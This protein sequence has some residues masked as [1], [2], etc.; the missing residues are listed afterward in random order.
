MSELTQ[1]LRMAVQARHPLLYLHSAEENRVLMALEELSVEFFAGAPLHV[2]TCVDGLAPS[3]DADTRDPVNAVQAALASKEDG[4][5]V[6]HDLSAFLDDPGVVRALRQAYFR[7]QHNPRKVLAIVSPV[8]TIPPELE[9][10]TYL[11][12]VPLPEST[13]LLAEAKRIQDQYAGNAIPAEAEPAVSLALRG[14]TL[15]EV[16]H[17]MHRVF[18]QG[19]A[20]K[21]AILDQIFQEKKRLIRKASF[22]EFVPQR[23]DIARIGGL[24]NLKEWALN[25]R[26]MFTSDA[27]AAGLPIPRGVLIMG[28]SGCGKSM[29]AKALASLWDLPLFRLDMNLIF[30][31]MHGSPHAA[32]HKAMRAIEAVAPAVL[33]IDE[34]ESALG[35]TVG[36]TT[37]DQALT[38][39]SFLTWMQERPPLVFVAATANRIESMP[40]EVIRKGRFDHVFFCDLP[41]TVERLEILRIHLAINGARPDEVDPER[42]L[43]STKGWSGAEIEQ[44]IVS[45]RIDALKAGRRFNT[46]DVRRHTIS[47]VPLSETMEEQVRAIRSWAFSRATR[48]S[49]KHGET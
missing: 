1:D 2:W 44:A 3:H 16:G 34:I 46:E 24:E 6:F 19:R 40:A 35:M 11:I 42:L 15:N 21:E 25:R 43:N 7:L 9:N 28:V 48:A 36:D 23:V 14:L 4:L 47:M 5:Y 12:E 8:V 29:T 49:I 39:A 27:V 41:D 37:P 26:G 10:E 32:F 33:W 13:E 18:G 45:A 30:S 38:F 31:G 17:V 20:G 22:L